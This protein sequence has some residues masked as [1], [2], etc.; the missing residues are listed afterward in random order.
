MPLPDATY[1]PS[2]YLL[3]GGLRPLGRPSLGYL[4]PRLSEGARYQ[5]AV[6]ALAP[7]S[8]LVLDNLTPIW[9][10]VRH[11]NAPFAPPSCDDEALPVRLAVQ[12]YSSLAAATGAP[13][14]DPGVPQGTK[15]AKAAAAAAASTAAPVEVCS[16]RAFSLPTEFSCLRPVAGLAAGTRRL[17]HAA[18]SPGLPARHVL[19]SRSGT[20]LRLVV[21]SETDLLTAC[22][23]RLG[24]FTA[25]SLSRLLLGEDSLQL[26]GAGSPAAPMQGTGPPEGTPPPVASTP[27]LRKPPRL[28]VSAIALA[29]PQRDCLIIP[30]RARPGL[31]R[32]MGL[33]LKR[34]ATDTWN[35]A[36]ATV[37]GRYR[38]RLVPSAR[39]D[40]GAR[41]SPR[42]AG[43]SALAARSAD[44]L[45]TCVVDSMRAAFLATVLS[46]VLLAAPICLSDNSPVWLRTAF[47]HLVTEALELCGPTFIKLGQWA[48]TRPDMLPPE[49]ASALS[50]LHSAVKP[51]SAAVARASLAKAVAPAQL[52]SVFSRFEDVPV[53][54]GCIAQVHRAVLR[55]TGQVVAV[56]I[57]HPGVRKVVERDL[58]LIQRAAATGEWLI[59]WIQV[60]GAANT[61]AQVMREQMDFR[62]EARHLDRF[63]ENFDGVSEVTF[64]MPVWP[65]VS[66]EVVVETFL[67]GI[68]ISHFLERQDEFTRSLSAVGLS[69]FLKMILVDNYIH[70][71]LH[72][73]NIIVQPGSLVEPRPPT[74]IRGFFS[75]LSSSTGRSAG[76][77]GPQEENL[78]S[79]A[80]LGGPAEG[81]ASAE[82]PLGVLAW[83]QS[84]FFGQGLGSSVARTQ[85]RLGFVDA[86]IVVR[87]NPADRTNFVD[88][89]SAVVFG[90]GALAATLMIERSSKP[91]SVLDREGFVR[92][93]TRVIDFVQ[94]NSFKLGNVHVSE[95]L[96]HVLDLVRVHRVMI[97]TSFTS[98]IMG[99]IILEGLGRQL[100][101][102]LD[103]LDV[104]RP[105]LA[106]ADGELQELAAP[107]RMLAAALTARSIA[108]RVIGDFT[109]PEDRTF[110]SGGP[111]AAQTPSPPPSPKFPTL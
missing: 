17:A 31:G 32:Q 35:M 88:L 10:T 42:L 71:D 59:P 51:H 78:F 33:A 106:R 53:G 75:R 46:P 3:L 37:T 34:S 14:T 57:Q 91:E 90:R 69:A 7:N 29:R 58:R 64:P 21:R 105:W 24:A 68:P 50:R 109:T 1:H 49:A 39:A 100:Y 43:P 16:D 84:L 80:R 56:T 61:F 5:L 40:P 55:Q 99:I 41:W 82:G 22:I 89:F 74:G 28:P 103:L 15:A 96:S 107:S 63:L 77:S 86:G 70:A 26:T 2:R 110:A 8:G 93:M 83:L 12:V 19:D 94:R 108:R 111:D 13:C 4:V 104:A 30:R 54:A 72:P 73:G 81:A 48:A 27:G 85:P 20:P 9:A 45:A 52:A 98:L 18:S 65:Y 101:P 67:Q 47:W 79:A 36:W 87:L 25:C 44:F 62:Q 60:T 97:D 66:R 102:N 38:R 11:R 92:E 23:H 95:V 76:S 6:S